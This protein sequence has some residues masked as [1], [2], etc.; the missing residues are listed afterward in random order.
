M[1]TGRKVLLN[2]R[3]EL[4]VKLLGDIGGQELCYCVAS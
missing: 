3:R 2:L 4:I 1:L